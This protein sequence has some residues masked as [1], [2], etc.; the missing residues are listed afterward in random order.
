M[1]ASRGSGKRERASASATI[2]ASSGSPSVSALRVAARSASLRSAESV[3]SPMSSTRRAKA[4]AAHIA[5]R[6]SAGRSRMP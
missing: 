3:P 2:T 1:N 6:L 4:Y 5:R